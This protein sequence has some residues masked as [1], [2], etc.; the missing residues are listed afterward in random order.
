MT[1]GSIILSIASLLSG[2]I[3]MIP[4]RVETW[5]GFGYL[6]FISN[7]VTFLLFL[8]TMGVTIEAR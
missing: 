8:F 6:I 3:W 2:E 4:T 1:V 5:L 7:L